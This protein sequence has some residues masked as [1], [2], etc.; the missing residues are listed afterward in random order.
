MI[1]SAEDASCSASV[2]VAASCS[3]EVV[4]EASVEVSE[5]AGFRVAVGFAQHPSIAQHGRV[6]GQHERSF[7]SVVSQ[8]RRA[9]A[10][11]FHRQ[12]IDHGCR[13]LV[14][15]RRLVDV[16]GHLGEANSQLRE[17]FD[18]ARRSRSQDEPWRWCRH[19]FSLDLD[20]GSSKCPNTQETGGS[21]R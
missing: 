19:H 21:C 2:A 16:G 8:R 5:G 3:V 9:G 1:G 14:L 10:G 7:T 12:T 4:S 13:R 11:L 15:K 18:P 17:Q 20:A 6:T